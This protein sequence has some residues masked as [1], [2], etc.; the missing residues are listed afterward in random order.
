MLEYQP[1]CRDFMASIDRTDWL[2]RTDQITRTG[3]LE[4]VL[5]AADDRAGPVRGDRTGSERAARPARARVAHVRSLAKMEP[6]VTVRRAD[7]T[8]DVSGR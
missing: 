2:V 1:K 3:I 7:A 8:R 4:R 6:L 5:A